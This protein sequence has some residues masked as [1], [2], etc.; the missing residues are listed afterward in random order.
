MK[1]TLAVAVVSMMALTVQGIETDFVLV[2]QG[3]VEVPG[4]LFNMYEMQLTT[5]TDWTNSR[6][7]VVLTAGL[8]GNNPFGDIFVPGPYFIPEF[9]ELANDTYVAT[10]DDLPDPLLPSKPSTAGSVVFG[11]TEIG[12]SWFDTNNTGPFTGARIAQIALS[13]DAVGTVSG[14]SYDIDSQGVGVDIGVQD[15]VQGYWTIGPDETHPGLEAGHFHWVPE[16]ATLSLFAVG[17]VLLRHRR[18]A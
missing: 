5:N 12:I 13:Q 14:K 3:A 16:P 8:F 11:D 6:L 7:D 4:P 2:G 17:A 15:G 1:R 10:P 9:L 18:H